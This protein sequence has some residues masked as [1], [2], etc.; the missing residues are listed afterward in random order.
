[1]APGLVQLGALS[2][3]DRSEAIR[4]AAHTLAQGGLVVFPTETVYGVGASA[5]SGLDR[6]AAATGQAK[7]PGQD[8]ADGRPGPFVW[9]TASLDP[10]LD[11][12][13]LETPV[14][15]RLVSRLTPGPVQLVLHQPPGALAA[16]R[17][18]LGVGENV[19]DDGESLH[20]RVPDHP[21]ARTLLIECAFPVVATLASAAPWAT[22]HT[23]THGDPILTVGSDSPAATDPGPDAVL[24]DGPTRYKAA[25]TAVRIGLDG[26]FGVVRQGAMSERDV[27]ATLERTILFVCTGNTCR[28]PMARAIAEGLVASEPPSGITTVVRSAGVS[29]IDGAPASPEA[30]EAMRARGLVLTRHESHA[31]TAAM[32]DSADVVYTMTPSHA[33]AVMRLVPSAAHKVFPLDPAGLVPDP[34][35]MPIDEYEH[36]AARL[37]EL[38]RDRLR[39]MDA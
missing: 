2:P 14:A 16:V 18:R 8:G 7:K 36:T 23:D 9:H 26:S 34:I 17:E 5:I 31:L 33:E 37:E 6:F 35:G 22:A 11:L 19:I 24:N 27:M 30:V 12:L 39:E 32:V 29:A 13:S 38:I 15:R 25:S 21:V 1:M 4:E 3:H 20:V 28:S 10:V